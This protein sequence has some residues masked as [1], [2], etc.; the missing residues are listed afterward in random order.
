MDPRVSIRVRFRQRHCFP[1]RLPWVPHVYYARRLV[2][3]EGLPALSNCAGEL[4][5]R[6]SKHRRRLTFSL[7][8]ALSSISLNKGEYRGTRVKFGPALLTSYRTRKEP[9]L[10]DRT[11]TE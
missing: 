1:K 4:F 7:A 3:E 9:D 11:A 2:M 10:G 6:S 8:P 5:V